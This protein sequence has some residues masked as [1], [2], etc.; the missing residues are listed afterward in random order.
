MTIAAIVVA[1]CVGFLFGMLVQKRSE[2][3]SNAHMREEVTR[4]GKAIAETLS[5]DQLKEHAS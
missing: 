2:A 3:E 1:M 4:L 5:T